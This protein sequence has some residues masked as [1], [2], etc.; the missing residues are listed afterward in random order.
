M[1]STQR[2]HNHPYPGNPV[3]PVDIISN[4]SEVGKVA[5]SAEERD[6]SRVQTSGL[7][8]FWLLRGLEII[9]L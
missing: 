1:R 7:H 5:V 4:D 6:S 2:A 3:H 8:I 9:E